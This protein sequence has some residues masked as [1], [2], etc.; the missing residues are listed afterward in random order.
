MMIEWGLIELAG[1]ICTRGWDALKN[2]SAL[3]NT[4]EFAKAHLE[5]LRKSIDNIQ[6]ISGHSQEVL[7]DGAREILK[8]IAAVVKAN[9]RDENVEVNANYMV[10]CAATDDVMAR[11]LFCD[12]KRRASSYAC[13]LE[14]AM[15]AKDGPDLPSK[16]I[17]PVDKSPGDMLFGAPRA[18]ATGKIDVVQNTKSIHRKINRQTHREIRQKVEDFFHDYHTHIR[19][20]GSIPMRVPPFSDR[21]P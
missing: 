12:S 2:K 5:N 3:Y 17:L 14:L 21:E 16:V 8:M 15:W 4:D 6:D 18:Y 9:I 10:P 13:F 7:R 19:S 1:E 20:F 11:A